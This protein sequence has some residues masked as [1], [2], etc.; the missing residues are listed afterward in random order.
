MP[1]YTPDYVDSVDGIIRQDTHFRPHTDEQVIH[2]YQPSEDLILERNA[3]MQKDAR[4][5]ELL[6]MQHLAEVP[7]ILMNQWIRD[8]PEM[9]APDAQTRNLALIRHIKANPQT[10]VVDP[11]TVNKIGQR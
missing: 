9:T 6:G 1:E 10:M 11:K 7:M 5:N 8:D 2:T 4:N 3:D